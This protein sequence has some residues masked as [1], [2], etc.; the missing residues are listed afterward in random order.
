MLKLLE[1]SMAIQTLV[2]AAV[3]KRRQADKSSPDREVS[4]ESNN[5]RHLLMLTLK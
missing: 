4:A 1:L 2:E 3:I 5:A